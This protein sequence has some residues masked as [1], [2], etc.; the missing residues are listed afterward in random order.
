MIKILFPCFFLWVL[1]SSFFCRAVDIPPPPPFSKNIE[2]TEVRDWRLEESKKKEIPPALNPIKR[3]IDDLSDCLEREKKIGLFSK[4]VNLHGLLIFLGE[5]RSDNISEL[6]FSNIFI[7]IRN[8]ADA[9]LAL[10]LTIDSKKKMSDHLGVLNTL[11]F[12]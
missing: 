3:A 4:L 1:L 11:F 12:I 8:L 7:K 5:G 2:K 10:D 6:S 9:I